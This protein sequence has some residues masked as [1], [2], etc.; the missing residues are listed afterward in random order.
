MP[1]VF[2]ILYEQS[3][4]AIARISYYNSIAATA[5]FEIDWK[6]LQ[7]G[8]DFR[9]L[10]NEC[11]ADAVLVCGREEDALLE[12]A[13]LSVIA[14]RKNEPRLV[15]LFSKTAIQ[16]INPPGRH[17]ESAATSNFDSERVLAGESVDASIKSASIV[18]TLSVAAD[19]QWQARMVVD[20][21]K[22]ALPS[23]RDSYSLMAVTD[24]NTFDLRLKNVQTDQVDIAVFNL[25]DIVAS[26]TNISNADFRQDDTSDFP[27]YM[28]LPLFECPPAILQSLTGLIVKDASSVLATTVVAAA[29]AQTAADYLRQNQL[30]RAH[31][32]TAGAFSMRLSRSAFTYIAGESGGETGGNIIDHWVMDAAIPGG[33]ILFST[34][35]FMKDFFDYEY[36]LT[37]E[38]HP[39][40][41]YFVASHKAA[42]QPVVRELLKTGHVWA[43][44]S[45]TWFELAKLGIWVEGCADG[46]GL[47]ALG[48]TWRSLK[49]P[50]TKAKV[51]ILTND[52]SAANWQQEGWKAVGT[53]KLVPRISDDI[54]AGLASAQVI[55]WTS[56]QQYQ[57]CREYLRQDVTH[58]SPAGKTAV[59]LERDGISDLLVFPSIK[60]FLWWRK[61]K[62]KFSISLPIK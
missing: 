57:A 13:G 8:D 34:T 51:T 12:A 56:Y 3:T 35:D 40:Q 42:H 30:V 59:M 54:I 28:I 21:L 11:H 10:L 39:S 43:A 2:T 61:A 22:K 17:D 55:F 23:P 53:Y 47:E 33:K 5:G 37:D 49:P 48:D 38:L 44:G 19:L 24:G 9:I 36:N 31:Y 26:G 46:L 20:F 15:A 4:P 25:C 62:E 45:R 50:F 7:P 16:L 6:V 60:A 27:G 41:V 58:A 1:Q 18:R 14:S 52:D 29:D 32:S